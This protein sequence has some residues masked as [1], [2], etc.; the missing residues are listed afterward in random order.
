L[1]RDGKAL[2]TTVHLSIQTDPIAIKTDIVNE[3]L[4][5]L[6]ESVNQSNRVLWELNMAKSREK[7][8]Q[9]G[10]WDDQVSTNKHDE[11]CLWVYQNSE[12][13]VKNL[14]PEQFDRPWNESDISS[15]QIDAYKKH[16]DDFSKTN[17]RKN[18]EIVGKFLEKV[19]L[20]SGTN[21]YS[22]IVGYAD[23]TIQV[24]IPKIECD[25]IYPNDAHHGITTG[26]VESNSFESFLIE[27]KSIFPTIGE[28]M[29]QLNLYRT[30][31]KGKI[32]VVAPDCQFKK[33]LKEQNIEFIKYDPAGL[34]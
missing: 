6:S 5:K 20:T 34:N 11:I 18:P 10:L 21:N 16:I 15:A 7:T 32:C 2:V 23:V 19:L 24:S 29:R 9:I 25:R 28:L 31:F 17:K 27:V 26:L 13:I 4:H 12:R 3:I 14:I 30:V 8:Q 22:R 1:E 33:I